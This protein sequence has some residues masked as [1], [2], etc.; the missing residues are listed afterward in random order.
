MKR[1]FTIGT[2]KAQQ[3]LYSGSTSIAHLQTN[4][5]LSHQ[6]VK[7]MTTI[8]WEIWRI[9]YGR[10]LA[11][12]ED[13]YWPIDNIQKLCLN[14]MMPSVRSVGKLSLSVWL[15]HN[16]APVHKSLVAQQA[17]RDCISSTEP[18]CLQSRP[19]SWWLLSVQLIFVVPGLQTMNH[20]KLLLKHGLKG[21]TENLCSSHKHLTRKMAKMH[22]RRRTHYRPIKRWQCD[23]NFAVFYIEVAKLF[24]RPSYFTRGFWSSNIS[25]NRKH[26]L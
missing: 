25:C 17:I 19:G 23:W 7:V 26:M 24:D 20:Q 3:N 2:Q 12:K 5:Q 6:L 10:L 13:N 8:F 11:F 15:L 21:R 4:L 16:H 14:C 9:T 18:P 1:G 22:W